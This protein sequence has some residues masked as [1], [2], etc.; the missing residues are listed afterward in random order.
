MEG[1]I[2]MEEWKKINKAYK[3]REL[4]GIIAMIVS[5]IIGAICDWN[6]LVER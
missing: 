2:L 5:L 4:T 1:T 6:V 3:T